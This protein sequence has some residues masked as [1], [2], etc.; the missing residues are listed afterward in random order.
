MQKKPTIAITLGDP[1]GIGPEIVFRYLN[2]LLLTNKELPFIP[3]VFGSKQ[4]L[5]HSH[6]KSLF[7]LS[8]NPHPPTPSP[9]IGR[10]GDTVNY[11]NK[12]L[13]QLWERVYEVGVRGNQS[14]VKN[15]IIFF[16]CSPLSKNFITKKPSAENGLASF[17]YL[18]K[19]ID[20]IKNGE[21][22]ALVTAPICKESWQ[23]AG[24]KY[25]DHTSYLKDKTKAKTVN[26]GFWT[27]K[28]KTVLVTIHKPLKEI[29]KLITTDSL[30]SAIE[31]TLLFAKL[32]KIK[33]PK[34]AI[35]GLNP[36]AGE[37]GLFG[38]EEQ[39]IIIPLLKKLNQNIIGP[40]PPDTV[41]FRAIQ[42]E[43]D[44]V[45][46]LYHDQALIPIKLLAFDS[47]VNISL[48]LPFIRTSPD[49]G[50]AFDRAYEKESSFKSFA[51][52]VKLALKCL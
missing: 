51:N 22:D 33:N 2:H 52:A 11:F 27:K 18:E 6:L 46:S 9:A 30:N 15:K 20:A 17:Q 13:S 36:H 39:D 45:I 7:C 25:H 41:Y 14:S 40:L 28:L 23:L 44:F 1:G 10:G 26:M 37:N 42:G 31:N 47:A 38:N 29:P 49:H 35:A 34:I 8:F 5:E 43:F 32:L 4:V 19:A 3:M 48:G 50:T 24:L 12:T 16:D 21:A